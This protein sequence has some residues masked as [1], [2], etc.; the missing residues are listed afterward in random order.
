MVNTQMQ[1]GVT[2]PAMSSMTGASPRSSAIS[3]QAGSNAKLASLNSITG[4]AVVVPQI[5]GSYT[6]QNGSQ[7][8]SSQMTSLTATGGQQYQNSVYDAGALKKGGK[9][10]TFGNRIG[11]TF[12]NRIGKRIGKTFGNRIGKTFGKRIGKRMNNK[13]FDNRMNKTKK[14]IYKKRNRTKL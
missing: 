13:R 11:K 8:P 2:Y 5:S 7:G 9:M 3:A 1:A 10:K 14:R 12:G 4:G 6:Q